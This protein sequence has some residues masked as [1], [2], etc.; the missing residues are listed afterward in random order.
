MS[1]VDMSY[2]TGDEEET[3]RG[4][5]AKTTGM[6]RDT[7][8]NS[9]VDR[10]YNRLDHPTGPMR[11]RLLATSEE[12]GIYEKAVVRWSTDGIYKDLLVSPVF[13]SNDNIFHYI[14]TDEQSPNPKAENPLGL[15][16]RLAPPY[17]K[18]VYE[19]CVVDGKQRVCLLRNW[20]V[21][22]PL[23][24]P[25]TIRKLTLD[26]ERIETLEFS[27]NAR[28]LLVRFRDGSIGIHS[29]A[30]DRLIHRFPFGAGVLQ[31]LASSD[32]K[33]ILALGADG[34]LDKWDL[35]AFGPDGWADN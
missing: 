30:L 27:Q 4:L 33:H 26:H 15:K 1:W 10:S 32:G 20:Y 13:V 16:L 2:K 12:A 9:H 24:G 19:P 21:S 25:T 34:R 6:T 7:L 5:Y 29:I 18:P 31:I 11:L 17:V 35:T 14:A 23:E 28:Y 22:F 8:I 3:Y